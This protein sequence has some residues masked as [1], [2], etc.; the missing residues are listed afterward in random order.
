M[1]PDFDDMDV[2]TA[3]AIC[4]KVLSQDGPGWLTVED[5]RALLA[6]AT[7]PLVQGGVARTAD[8]A[9]NSGP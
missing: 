2:A 5:T 3:R 7:L 9:V 8:Q 6:S 4:A 1:I